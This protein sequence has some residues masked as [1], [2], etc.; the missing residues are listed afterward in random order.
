MVLMPL[1]TTC[2]LYHDGQFIGGGDRIT[3][4]NHRPAESYRQTLSHNIVSGIPRQ[5]G[6]RSIN[7]PT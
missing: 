3:E 4:E 1:S 7:L 2:Q 6:R 5:Y